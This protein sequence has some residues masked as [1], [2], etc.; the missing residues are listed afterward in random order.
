MAE[1]SDIERAIAA[2]RE[3]VWVDP[4]LDARVMAEIARLPAP[5]PEPGWRRASRWLVRAPAVRLSPLTA[6]AAAASIVLATLVGQ[7]WLQ[8]P[9]PPASPASS[10][11]SAPAVQ[12]VV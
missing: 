5:R 9:A 4:A 10:A 8:A 1:R 2:W 6:F 11:L 7:E 3:P 12:F